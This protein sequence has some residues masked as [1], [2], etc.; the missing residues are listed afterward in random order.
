[1]RNRY[2]L[3]NRSSSTNDFVPDHSAG[4][5]RPRLRSRYRIYPWILAL[6]LLPILVWIALGKNTAPSSPASPTPDSDKSVSSS[7][8]SETQEGAGIW[9]PGEPAEADWWNPQMEWE[10]PEEPPSTQEDPSASATTASI[11]HNNW[12]NPDLTRQLPARQGEQ[13]IVDSEGR[14]A[15]LPEE[16]QHPPVSDSPSDSDGWSV[17][18]PS[19]EQPQ[20]IERLE[21][22]QGQM[23]EV[24]LMGFDLSIDG[25]IT[26]LGED[27]IRDAVSFAREH[28][29]RVIPTIGNRFSPSMTQSIL[30]DTEKREQAVEQILALVQ[31][32]E[33]D[34]VNIL[35]QPMAETERDAFA[36]WIESLANRLH[37]EEKALTV[38]VYPQTGQADS[39][40]AQRA[41]DWQ[42]IGQAADQVIIMA[43]NYS[44]G[45]PGPSTP[46]EW[47]DQVI[48]HAKEQIEPSKI[49]IALSTMGWIWPEENPEAQRA[50]SYATYTEA[51]NQSESSLPQPQRDENGELYLNIEHQ[52]Q[53]YQAWYMDKTSLETKIDWI[54]T[55]HSDI[56]GVA[57]WGLGNEDPEIW[58]EAI[59]LPGG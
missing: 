18:F 47:L 26:S 52:E 39:H 36:D 27:G 58:D 50:F 6:L 42:R 54:T 5:S 8:T 20:A 49:T 17:W 44:W 2:E 11:L 15:P 59:R 24:Y 9:D 51:V 23:N 22:A 45:T 30:H 10:P 25:T 7:D 14:V 16:N 33:Y 34:G 1:L 3:D 29:I 35:F 57:L 41:Q 4:Q 28:G 48:E 43:Y 40:S 53:R 38:T 13:I 46:L 55:H 31:T 37:E 56:G 12:H 21:E 32:H 19:W